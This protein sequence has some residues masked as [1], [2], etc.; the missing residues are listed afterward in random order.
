VEARDQVLITFRSPLRFNS[1][2]F[3]RS[4]GATKGP[5]FS[6][7]DIFLLYLS[8]LLVPTACR[9]YFLPPRR[10]TMNLLVNLLR[11]VFLPKAGLPHGVLGPG[12]PIGERPSPPPCGWDSGSI[13]TPRTE[14]R[15]PKWRL[16]PALPKVML[17]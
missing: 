15:R 12:I 1:S 11:R 13:A 8:Q 6:E 4:F 2:T 14:E 16:R 9:H 17:P 5:F 3:L 10:R 7:R